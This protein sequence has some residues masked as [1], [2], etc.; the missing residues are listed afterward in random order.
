MPKIGLRFR[1]AILISVQQI[2]FPAKLHKPYSSRITIYTVRL[3]YICGGN[4]YI[5]N[6]SLQ[7][8]SQDYNLTSCTTHVA[9]VKVI[10]DQQF[11]CDLNDRCF[12][13]FFMAVFA[14]NLLRGSRRKN[15]FSYFDL[16]AISDLGFEPGL[17]I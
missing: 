9:Y 1:K 6:A 10:Q 7:S 13:D 5:H 15:K 12:R 2:V 14:R 11:K 8:I 16:L 3:A 17:H 4:P